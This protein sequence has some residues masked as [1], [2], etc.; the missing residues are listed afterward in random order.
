MTTGVIERVDSDLREA[1]R[2]QLAWDPEVEEAGIG[3]N[4]DDGVVTLTGFTPTY[5]TKLAAERAA[6]RVF[7]VRAIAN[8]LQV[9]LLHD[10]TDPDIARDALDAL[11]TRLTPSN[12]IKVTVRNGFITLEG[13]LE[14]FYQR[15]AAESCV[16]YLKGVRGVSNRISLKPRM[17]AGTDV[18]SKIEEALRR[19]A[20]VDARRIDVSITGGTVTLK[21][22]VSSW[23]ERREAERAA[24]SSPGVVN[25]E[26][27]LRIVA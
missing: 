13:E 27:E 8:D 17:I 1:V 4:A 5:A 18:K 11:R 20:L 7:G 15:T 19:L 9:K 23:A 10:R 16:K 12:E 14:W 26:N 6:K 21:G 2:R 24:W 3:I 22:N 25:V